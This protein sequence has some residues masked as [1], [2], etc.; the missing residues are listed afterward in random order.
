DL[1]PNTT[2]NM[3]WDAFAKVGRIKQV[4]LRSR[5]GELKAVVVFVTK[6]D[7]DA[8]RD[9]KI[10][11]HPINIIPMSMGQL[12]EGRTRGVSAISFAMG[13]DPNISSF[14]QEYI[15]T[16][17]V[18]LYINFTNFLEIQFIHNEIDYRVRIPLDILKTEMT[19]QRHENITSINLALKYPGYFYKR[20]HEG[21]WIR[22]T[23]LD[24]KSHKH[25]QKEPISVEAQQDIA[26]WNYYRI[27]FNIPQTTHEK[28]RESLETAYKHVKSQIPQRSTKIQVYAP[29]K[30]DQDV[31][32]HI[33]DIFKQLHFKVQYMIQ[34]ALQL[35]IIMFR[36]ISPRFCQTMRDLHPS[37]AEQILMLMTKK[38]TQV[39]TPDENLKAIWEHHKA[40]LNNDDDTMEG[41]VKIR[42]VVVTP[43]CMYPLK[44]VIKP[45]NLIQQAF[46]DYADHFLVVQFTDEE[47]QPIK[48]ST[49]ASINR[50][51]YDRIFEILKCGIGLCGRKFEFLC[52]SPDSLLEHTCWFFSS[53]KELSI[54]D[55]ID[56][57]GGFEE[58]DNLTD[59]IEATGQ[60]LVKPIFS[61][62]VKKEEIEITED[63]VVFNHNLTRGCGKISPYFAR[64]IISSELG[65]NYTPSVIEFHLAGTKG[66]LHV[67]NYLKG[68][69]IEIRD[70]QIYYNTDN[71]RFEVVRYA[72]PEKVYLNKHRILM[73][74][75]LGVSQ[76]VFIRLLEDMM[77]LIEKPYVHSLIN[78][79]YTRNG[80]FQD[81]DRIMSA[82][83]LERDP[84]IGQLFTSYQHELIRNINEDAKIYIPEGAKC[85][86]VMDETGTLESD[87]IFFQTM[88]DMEDPPTRRVIVGHVLIYGDSSCSP[89]DIRVF[90]ATDCKKL[91]HLS[92]VIVF[93]SKQALGLPCLLSNDPKDENHFTP[94]HI[95][96]ALMKV[97]ASRKE[98]MKFMIQYISN[99]N[100]KEIEEALVAYGDRDVK[101][102]MAGTTLFL[103]RQLAMALDFNRSGIS[104]SV[105][106]HLTEYPKP[107]FYPN[108]QERE[109]Y[110][111][112]S[113]LGHIY[114][115]TS[116]SMGFDFP[117]ISVTYD[118]RLF[119]KGMAPFIPEARRLRERY[120]FE[121]QMILC[122]YSLFS[123][124]ELVSGCVHK[125]SCFTY[126]PSDV[127][128]IRQAY[129][130]LRHRW[131]YIFENSTDDLLEK[132]AAWYYV[133]Y[134]PTE[135]KMRM[136][137]EESPLFYSFVWVAD[138]YL[139]DMALFYLDT[140]KKREEEEKIEKMKLPELDG[141]IL[142]DSDEK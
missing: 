61:F 8:F 59:Y 62:P 130:D 70:S 100:R 24:R 51:L 93:S 52:T 106:S 114:Q 132:A 39:Y 123:E 12:M 128:S 22:V 90:S 86:A 138:D 94:S 84:F 131:R 74:S 36:N 60:F 29:S 109:T 127:D 10:D 53:T 37:K 15:N 126:G 58:I 142:T 57:M 46:P 47:L 129:V 25:G 135:I 64:D 98:A 111:S 108:Q 139:C 21:L 101:G 105:P 56:T 69:R 41:Y 83:F 38:Q 23:E 137:N 102:A 65:L 67:S 32:R 34:H 5:D 91:H 50:A 110:S 26:H 95:E 92:N 79:Y 96:P 7:E 18:R 117:S 68:R 85:Y 11:G 78:E 72:K 6:L 82:R 124:L 63:V 1:K 44:P 43:T 115:I 99:D 73:L 134:H 13:V 14:V 87:E 48:P 75:S 31:K 30:K 140:E 40:N 55:M 77:R 88:N 76:T 89:D 66:I 49:P 45:I 120:D 27:E 125:Q 103:A 136:K 97:K 42:K 107:N 133:T 122:E 28:L 118:Q 104:G 141:L 4:D 35:R 3:L 80:I 81:F 9:V 119:H 71:F 17:K 33:K 113:I 121:L 20:N 16:Q 54:R 112:K 19:L 2:R 116:S